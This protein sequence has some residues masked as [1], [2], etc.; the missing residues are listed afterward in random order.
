MASDKVDLQSHAVTI[1]L[2]DLLTVAHFFWE[3][4]VFV[5]H[6]SKHLSG[7]GAIMDGLPELPDQSAH[8]YLQAFLEK[9]A[10]PDNGWGKTPSIPVED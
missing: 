5:A 6:A 7:D 10:E 4:L 1:E 3:T 9:I 8:H 2:T